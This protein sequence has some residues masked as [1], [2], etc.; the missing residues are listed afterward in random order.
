MGK[1]AE[2]PFDV[3]GPG[4]TVQR[5]GHEEMSDGIPGYAEPWERCGNCKHYEDLDSTCK[6]F[7]KPVDMEASCPKFEEAGDRDDEM[8]DNAEGMENG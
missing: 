1:L 6:M 8:M 3:S 4:Q 7:Q 2:L 5:E